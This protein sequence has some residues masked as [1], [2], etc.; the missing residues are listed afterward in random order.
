MLLHGTARGQTP[1]ISGT[2]VDAQGGGVAGAL[3]TLLTPQSSVATLRT[4]G[5]GSFRFA[6]APDGEYRVQVESPGFDRA[7]ETVRV[8]GGGVSLTVTLQVAGVT[9]GVLVSAPAALDGDAPTGSRLGLTARETPATINVIAQQEM[10]TR[11]LRTALEAYNSVPGV[12]ADYVV[13]DLLI[14]MRGFTGDA[15]STLYDG[16][17]IA[18]ATMVSRDVDT[19]TYD[20]VEVLKGPSSVLYGEGALAG[21]INM[22][23]KQAA[24]GRRSGEALVSTGSL[25]WGRLAGGVNQPLGRR[26]AVR[27]DASVNQSNG[28]VDDTDTR[29]VDLLASFLSRPTPRLSVRASFNHYRD[30]G[31]RYYTGAPLVPA[32]L[33]ADPS[34]IVSSTNGRV[35][36]RAQRDTNYNTTDAGMDTNS[37]WVRA[38]IEY[39]L[40]GNW[41]IN[42]GF[43]YF[44]A[45]RS[46]YNV[47]NAAFNSATNRLSRGISLTD[48]HH[49]F[50]AN[51]LTLANE[52]TLGGRRNRFAAGVEINQNDFSRPRQ[53]GTISEVS[54]ASPVRGLLAGGAPVA[55]TSRTTDYTVVDNL[56]IFAE[57]AMNLTPALVVV[58]SLRA[59]R[60]DVGRRLDNNAANT[61]TDFDGRFTPM[62]GRLGAVY[63]LH[64]DTQVFGQF[65]SA[66]VPL[67]TTLTLSQTNTAL[68]LT[69][70]KSWEGGVKSS[71]WRQ[72]AAV[73]ASVYHIAQDKILTVDPADV[74]NTVQGGRLS[75]RGVEIT[76]SVTP[77]PRFRFD[78]SVV[79]VDAQFDTLVEAGGVS[80]AGNRPPNVPARLLSANA[81]YDLARTPLTIGATL[82]A[83]GDVFID[84]ANTVKTKGWATLDTSAAYRMGRHAMTIRVRNVTNAFY[85][86]WGRSNGAAVFVRPPRSI[87][88][89]VTTSF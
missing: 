35:V 20:R 88:L 71:F 46:W 39:R 42:N 44:D 37:D 12:T 27:L 55:F 84:N 33:A 3:V 63:N 31:Q 80:R 58:G 54:L 13:G 1:G 75:S 65:S 78:S 87:D 43:N 5:D 83:A 89:G 38:S 77:A 14:S 7:I 85:A 79:F 70:G 24:L 23:P 16:F 66:V 30:S 62:S 74:N 40:N 76:G 15:I 60:L 59:E 22:V 86:D 47:N 53:L 73:T 19:F 50:W 68:D 32:A 29:M 34:D 57:D 56:A 64:S 67:S 81:Y 48:H 61:T 28:W 17:R 8:A 2:V 11:G 10:Q 49:E 45:F 51:R 41:T 82:R 69:T 72:R 4:L 52:A 21:A 25:N 18:S 9:E 36:D 6:D 26:S